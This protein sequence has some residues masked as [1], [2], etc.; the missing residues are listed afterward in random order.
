MIIINKKKD[1][2]LGQLVDLDCDCPQVGTAGMHSNNYYDEENGQCSWC[3]ATAP[4]KKPV[5]KTD[6]AY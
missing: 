1:E 2:S 5:T 6:R 4:I 3:G